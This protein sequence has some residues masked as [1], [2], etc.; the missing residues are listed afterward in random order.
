MVD[1]SLCAKRCSA[2]QEV[3]LL[4]NNSSM[5]QFYESVF[6]INLKMF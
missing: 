1:L 2:L 5:R 6:H 4:V 3:S